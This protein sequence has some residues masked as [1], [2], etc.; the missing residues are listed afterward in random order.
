[1]IFVNKHASSRFCNKK[2][3]PENPVLDTGGEVPRILNKS[4]K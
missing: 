3:C 1:M 2:R 4:W